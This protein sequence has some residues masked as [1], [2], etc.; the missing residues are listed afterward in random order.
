[1]PSKDYMKNL[2][3]ELIKEGGVSFATVPEEGIEF[4]FKLSVCIFSSLFFS[5]FYL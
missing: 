5:F 2:Q 1:M 4:K 3:Y